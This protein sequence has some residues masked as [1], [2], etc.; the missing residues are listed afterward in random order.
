MIKRGI[1]A[2]SLSVLNENGTLNI[3]ETISH[4]ESAIRSGLH[5]IFFLAQQAKAN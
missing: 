3:N 2:A 5:G 4:A 1:Y